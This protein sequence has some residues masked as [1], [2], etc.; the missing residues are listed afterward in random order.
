MIHEDELSELIAYIEQYGP[1][2]TDR[3][4]ILGANALLTE[5]A[6]EER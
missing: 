1:P 4:F 6:K 5:L 3:R 2:L